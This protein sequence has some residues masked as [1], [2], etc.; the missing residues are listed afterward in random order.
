MP[1][2]KVHPGVAAVLSALFTG[3]GQIYCGRVGRGLAIMFVGPILMVGFV[4]LMIVGTLSATND[5]SQTVGSLGAWSILIGLMSTFYWIFN[6]YDAYT[7]ACT[8]NQQQN[9]SRRRR[10]RR[11]SKSESGARRS[12]RYDNESDVSSPRRRSKV[13]RKSRPARRVRSSY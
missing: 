7:L 4:F 8:V 3:V 6:I 13:A 1:S 2:N 11:R 12:R 9:R 5:P 10:P